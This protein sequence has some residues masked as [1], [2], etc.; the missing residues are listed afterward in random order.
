MHERRRFPRKQ[1][2]YRA[3]FKG[4]YLALGLAQVRD[5]SEQGLFV[6]TP[7]PAPLNDMV[8]VNFDHDDLGKE[9]S[10]RCRVVRHIPRA[11]MGLEIVLN[12][13]DLQL[14]DWLRNTAPA[15]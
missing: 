12:T 11:G 14:K 5:I 2:E 1:V 8:I 15:T 6:E 3:L 7:Y 13:E 10:M 9:I 4:G